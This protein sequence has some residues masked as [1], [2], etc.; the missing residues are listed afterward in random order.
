[1]SK[2]VTFGYDIVFTGTLEVVVETKGGETFDD[3][4]KRSRLEVK[5][6][7]DDAPVSR[8][9]MSTHAETVVGYL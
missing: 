2:V 4:L 3:A 9:A 1:M 7:I 6:T 5:R 8:A